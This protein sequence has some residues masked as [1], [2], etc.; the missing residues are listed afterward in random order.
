MARAALKKFDPKTMRVDKN[1]P[2]VIYDSS[3]TITESGAFPQTGYILIG[4]KDNPTK[5]K[6]AEVIRH[7]KGHLGRRQFPIVGIAS[8]DHL[9]R[10]R[11]ELASYDQER[12]SSSARA[13]NKVLPSRIKQFMGYLTWV[14]KSDQR[15]IKAKA[16]RVLVSKKGGGNDQVI[17]QAQADLSQW[18]LEEEKVPTRILVETTRRPIEKIRQELS[19]GLSKPKPIRA[20]IAYTSK[21]RLSRKHHKGWKKVKY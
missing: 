3:C 4:V 8:L 9:T 18:W 7:E 14:S 20:G 13:W 5:Q 12:K 19:K 16:K 6:I 2:K 21:G 15:R 11:H 10:A 1:D 17:R